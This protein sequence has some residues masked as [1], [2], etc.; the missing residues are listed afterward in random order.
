MYF[1]IVWKH[2][3]PI[4]SS[5]YY[6]FFLYYMNLRMFL[7]FLKLLQIN[8]SKLNKV[9]DSY[10]QLHCFYWYKSVRFINNSAFKLFIVIQSCY[11]SAYRALVIWQSRIISETSLNDT[12]PKMT[13][14][15]FA[16]DSL[17]K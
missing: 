6:Y 8:L 17:Q 12:W 9:S 7:S 4:F 3:F 5:Y 11:L 15:V 14:A 13:S 10:L 1:L 2:L 16:T